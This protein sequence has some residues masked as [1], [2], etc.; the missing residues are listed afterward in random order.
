MLRASE[1]QIINAEELEDARK[2]MTE[3]QFAQ[4]YECSFN[5]AIQGAYYGKE[6]DA[7]QSQ[8]RIRS[9]PWEPTVPVVTG[10]D[11]GINDATV[12]WFAQMVGNEIRIIDHLKVSNQSLVETARTV[13]AKPYVYREHYLPHD[14][15]LRELMSGKSRRETLEGLGLKPIRPGKALPVEEGINAVKMALPRCVFD[16]VLCRD[17]VEALR[18]YRSEYDDKNKVFRPRPLHDWASHDAD[19]FRELMMQLRESAP[20]SGPLKPKVLTIG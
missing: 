14:V 5:A 16:A 7:L 4:E 2:T 11:L 10:W 17:G 19:A 8:G 1:T 15:E 3:D 20:K 18:H 9:V 6:L 12:V 13:L